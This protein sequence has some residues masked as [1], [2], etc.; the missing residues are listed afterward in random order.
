MSMR[1]RVLWPV[2]VVEIVLA[3]VGARMQ[4]WLFVFTMVCCAAAALSTIRKVGRDRR[5]G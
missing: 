3:V 4:E 2:S 1:E 5:A